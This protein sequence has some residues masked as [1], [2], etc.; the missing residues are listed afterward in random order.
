MSDVT[1]PA[2]GSVTYTVKELLARQDA[3]L[4]TIILGLSGKA[5]KQDL[6][7]IAARMDLV[8]RSQASSSGSTN[9]M[10]RVAPIF[11]ALAALG[12]ALASWLKMP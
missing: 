1:E 9:S 5:E 8:E 4:D 12:L 6:E 3:K 2:N 10:W 11:A 7:R